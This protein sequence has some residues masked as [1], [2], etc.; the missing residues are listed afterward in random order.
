[1]SILYFPRPSQKTSLT[2]LT[3]LTE[4]TELTVLTELTAF[5][6]LTE[7]TELTKLTCNSN[8]YTTFYNRRLQKCSQTVLQM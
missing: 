5:T 2:A 3:E 1:M 4:L 6:E 8:S 7:L